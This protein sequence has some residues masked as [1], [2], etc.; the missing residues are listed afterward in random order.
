MELVQLPTDDAGH[1]RGY[2][3][4]QVSIKFTAGF[5][6]HGVWAHGF[7][8]MPGQFTRLEDARAAQSLHGQIGIA[9]KILKVS[10]LV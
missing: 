7:L 4:V 2:G 6:L 9:G 8:C 1:C 3:F 10:M 5:V